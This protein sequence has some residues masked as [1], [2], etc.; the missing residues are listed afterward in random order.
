MKGLTSRNF[1]LPCYVKTF[2]VDDQES[3]PWNHQF[4]G[5]IPEIVYHFK[6]TR[7]VRRLSKVIDIY[8]FYSSKFI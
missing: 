3:L 6:T 8:F 2:E 7:A 5:R 4:S 1:K